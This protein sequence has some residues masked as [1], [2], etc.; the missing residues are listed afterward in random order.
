METFSLIGGFKNK[1]LIV[2]KVKIFKT[3]SKIKVWFGL[4]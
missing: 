3:Y 4:F 2:M 1:F